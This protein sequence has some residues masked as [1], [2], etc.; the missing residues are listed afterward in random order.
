MCADFFFVPSHL[1]HSPFFS[2]SILV[3]TQIRGHI[4]RSSPPSRLLYVRLVPCIL[5]ARGPKLFLPSSTR[6]ELCSSLFLPVLRYQ[7]S[8]TTTRW[9]WKLGISHMRP[10][11]M[12]KNWALISGDYFSSFED[13]EMYGWK[14]RTIWD[15][16]LWEKFEPLFLA[17]IFLVLRIQKCMGEK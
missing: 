13:S 8:T 2:L 12:G 17:I 14:I 5:I 6:V 7:V 15:Q 10:T 16:L 3:V 11:L 1:L 4:A 9:N